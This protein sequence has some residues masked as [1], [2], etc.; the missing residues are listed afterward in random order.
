MEFVG[1]EIVIH[2][3]VAGFGRFGNGCAVFAFAE[4]VLHLAADQC[5]IIHVHQGLCGAVIGTVVSRNGGSG[6]FGHVDG[7]LAVHL[8]HDELRRHVN[9][10]AVLDDRSTGHS[11]RIH[12]G[13]CA[14]GHSFQSGDCV[15]LTVKGELQRLEAADTLLRSVNI[16]VNAVGL[17]RDL[18][19]RIAVEHME[20]RLVAVEG[21]EAFAAD[22]GTDVIGA[23]IDR[24]ACAPFVA[25]I[26]SI[27]VSKAAFLVCPVISDV[28]AGGR[29]FVHCGRRRRLRELVVGHDY[30]VADPVL[31]L[32]IEGRTGGN[33]VAGVDLFA[34]HRLGEP[35]K[36]GV[37]GAGGNR[38]RGGQL[39]VRGEG[40]IGVG[41]VAA[42]GGDIQRHGI[43]GANLHRGGLSRGGQRN[44]LLGIGLRLL[45]SQRNCI[46]V[47]RNTGKHVVPAVQNV[48]RYVA[49]VR[50]LQRVVANLQGDIVGFV[51]VV[52]D[53]GVGAVRRFILRQQAAEVEGRGIVVGIEFLIRLIA[54]RI[55]DPGLCDHSNTA[56]GNFSSIADEISDIEC[57]EIGVDTFVDIGI[58]SFRNRECFRD[59]LQAV[60]VLIEGE[61]H[62][63]SASG[64][65]NVG[66]VVQNHLNVTGSVALTQEL[67]A[68]DAHI[69]MVQH[70]LTACS[71][72]VICRNGVV[73][74][75]QVFGRHRI[76]HRQRHGITGQDVQAVDCFALLAQRQVH[77]GHRRQTGIRHKE[78]YR[79]VQAGGQLL[80][81]RFGLDLD[82]H[83]LERGGA[84]LDGRHRLFRRQN[85][86]VGTFALAVDELDLICRNAVIDAAVFAA[87]IAAKRQY[88]DL[89]FGVGV[90]ID[91]VHSVIR[92]GVRNG[93][94]RADADG[95]SVLI[96]A[97]GVHIILLVVRKLCPD[98]GESVQIRVFRGSG[99]GE[100]VG[101][102][103]NAQSLREVGVH[104]AVGAD[105]GQ[106]DVI[107]FAHRA[108]GG[109]AVA[110]LIL[111]IPAKDEGIAQRHDLHV[112]VGGVVLRQT[113]GGN[114]VAVVADDRVEGFGGFGFFAGADGIGQDGRAVGEHGGV[115]SVHCAR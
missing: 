85:Q 29:L 67:H 15:G 11:R 98:D 21:V 88:I 44:I 92:A 35:A 103:G 41:A 69:G 77:T 110:C 22:L 71:C 60:A 23:G 56:F 45:G 47:Q 109:G 17:H 84:Q 97:H 27:A 51:A 32:R 30:I 95:I 19:F 55:F 16:I 52:S 115:D 72:G 70:K 65:G 20:C 46:F 83:G 112:A 86:T 105:A 87:V 40:D 64:K 31:V 34:A 63:L 94:G 24:C 5:G 82:R 104:A 28:N 102:V 68:A 96:E 81:I 106:T 80:E 62:S 25:E 89:A 12:A 57:I 14:F 54:V 58:G 13:F 26:N 113:A 99:K 42:V 76:G 50:L 38:Q 75:C 107:Y 59:R 100:A 108:V 90:G 66:D 49:E 93:H 9:S 2:S 91:A 33:L 114:R 1:N 79:Q 73:C 101:D 4:S 3:V 36:E 74:I 48:R 8:V 43:R 37:D 78:A 111:G 53:R 10:C 6:S 39:A 7:Q 18:V 61:L